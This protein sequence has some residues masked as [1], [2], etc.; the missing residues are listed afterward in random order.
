MEKF[1]PQKFTIFLVKAFTQY[2]WVEIKGG[3][4]SM[5]SNIIN[6]S[7]PEHDV[8]VNSFWMM[9]TEVTLGMYLE[10]KNHGDCRYWPNGRSSCEY[11]RVN[12]SNRETSMRP[13]NCV[14]ASSAQTFC[15]WIGGRLP[16]E[17]EWEYAAGSEGKDHIYPWGNEAPSC[18]NVV[19]SRCSKG[20]DGTWARPQNPCSTNDITEQG[21]CDLGGNV[22]EYVID[23]WHGNYSG[24][25]TDGSAWGNTGNV[26][27]RGGNFD[28]EMH[29][30]KTRFRR[31]HSRTDKNS[32]FGFRCV[33]DQ[34]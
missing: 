12:P 10:C 31:G 2:K 27:V 15:Q 23:Q 9:K 7:G 8:S 17:S 20:L 26:V 1:T 11:L 3:T 30:C 34:L 24:H 32:L 4:F 13:A 14:T 6:H 25:P 16:T 22:G 33:R 19:A 29:Q 21:I 18:E 5:G 28:K